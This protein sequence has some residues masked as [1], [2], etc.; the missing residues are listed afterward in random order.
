MHGTIGRSGSYNQCRRRLDA[1]FPGQ[2]YRRAGG[3]MAVFAF[4]GVDGDYSKVSSEAHEALLNWLYA[5][6]QEIWVTTL[7]EALDWAKDLP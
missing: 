4:H 2:R 1:A 7:Q 5:H 3:G 6:R